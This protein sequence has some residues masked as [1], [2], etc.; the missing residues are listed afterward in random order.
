[1]VAPPSAVPPISSYPPPPAYPGN[2]YTPINPKKRKIICGLIDARQGAFVLSCL[3]IMFSFLF[4]F[5]LFFEGLVLLCVACISAWG[6]YRKSRILYLP[7]ICF[8]LVNC[9]LLIGLTIGA[10]VAIFAPELASAYIPYLPEF[11]KDWY[12]YFAIACTF[13]CLFITLICFWITEVFF[14]AYFATKDII[15]HEKLLSMDI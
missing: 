12:R 3:G 2:S 5:I 6:Y 1:M 11:L 9:L 15:K 13:F 7:H 4:L 10:V 8:L 14:K